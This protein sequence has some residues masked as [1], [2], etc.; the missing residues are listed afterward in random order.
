MHLAS[1]ES[2]YEQV[3]LELFLPKPE[4]G[5]TE[6]YWLSGTDFGREGLFYWM[7][8]GKSFTY[9]NWNPS[10]PNNYNG[11]EHCVQMIANRKSTDALRWYD[12]QCNKVGYVVCQE[13]YDRRPASTNAFDWVQERDNSNRN[14]IIEQL[15]GK[16]NL[17]PFPAAEINDAPMPI[18]EPA[19]SLTKETAE[20]HE[21]PKN[22]I[23]SGYSPILSA[24][25]EAAE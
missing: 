25:A 13:P 18:V 24:L 3:F 10:E 16:T 12:A 5:S 17:K 2:T 9:T 8:S 23:K 14:K 15:Q 11:R 7:N 6:G 20:G 4:S 22:K 19:T 21:R 1:V